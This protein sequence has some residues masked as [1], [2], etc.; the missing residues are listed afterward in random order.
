[1]AREEGAADAPAYRKALSDLPARART[2]G[3]DAVMTR[4]RLDALVAPD[5]QPGVAD[6]SRQR[7]SLPRR[8]LDARRGRRLSE[9]HRAGRSVRAAGRHLVLRPR[10]ERADADRA[11]LRLRAGHEASAAARVPAHRAALK[12]PRCGSDP[13]RCRRGCARQVG[14]RVPDVARP[15][16]RFYDTP[17]RHPDRRAQH[18]DADHH[19]QHRPH[20]GRQQKQPRHRRRVGRAAVDQEQDADVIHRVERHLDGQQAEKKSQRVRHAL[21]GERDERDTP[22]EHQRRSR[23]DCASRGRA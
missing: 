14:F 7:R 19:P 12:Q 5:G 11:R 6:R 18:R 20:P 16:R 2:R 1:M 9:H 4:H 13:S 22:R 3:I 10:L 15:E 17:A 21:A 8:E 23:T